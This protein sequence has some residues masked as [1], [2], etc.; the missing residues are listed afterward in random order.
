[1]DLYDI[2]YSSG[3]TNVTGIAVERRITGALLY[4]ASGVTPQIYEILGHNEVPLENLGMAQMIE[5]E[6]YVL[7]QLNLV[8]SS[9]PGDASAI[10]L[11]GPR[12][13]LLPGEVEKLLG[14][15]EK[16]GRLLALVDF[17]I[18]EL[19]NLNEFFSSYGIRF[20][21]GVV[22]EQDQNYVIGTPFNVI[23]RFQENDITKPLIE[24][25]SPVILPYAMGISALDTR[26]RTVKLEP[27]LFSSNASFLKRELNN[28]STDQTFADGPGPV[29]MG[30]TVLDPEYAQ[31]E[32]QARIVAI[33]C[34]SLLEPV[35]AFQQIPGNIDLFMNSLTWLEDK[36]ENL[37]VRSRSLFLLPMRM[38]GLHIL[39]FGS[40]FMVLIPLGFFVSGF[41]VWMKRR[42]L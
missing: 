28:N 32:P 25:R 37:S 31:N 8:Q 2:D 10:I 34:G 27:F 21:Y 20:D 5:R 36:P 4:T 38:S 13:D 22:I 14:Y 16:G 17:R 42:H 18:R 11:N 29:N 24:N 1:M 26:R 41:V 15:L 23:P 9:V 3:A 33:S 35:N 19:P 6:N 30:V 40:V 12:S 39:V 7:K